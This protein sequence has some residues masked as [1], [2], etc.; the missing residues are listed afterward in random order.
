MPRG[1]LYH[2]VDQIIRYFRNFSQLRRVFLFRRHQETGRSSRIRAGVMGSNQKSWGIFIFS[3]PSPLQRN[4]SPPMTPIDPDH[5]W[6]RIP[7]LRFNVAAENQSWEPSR[8]GNR[9]R[10][11]WLSRISKA[12]YRQFCDAVYRPMIPLV[13]PIRAI[14][15]FVFLLEETPNAALLDGL[16]AYQ[17]R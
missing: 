2:N 9:F 5:S 14:D 7:I 1:L 3:V 4:E 10:A 13:V 17:L 16:A 11:L 8:G 12:N 15:I 6:D